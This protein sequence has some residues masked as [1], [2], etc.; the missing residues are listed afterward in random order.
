MK[1]HA[2]QLFAI[3][4]VRD[5]FIFLQPNFLQ[6]NLQSYIGRPARQEFSEVLLPK[7]F[8]NSNVALSSLSPVPDEDEVED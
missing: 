8:C 7:V 5:E 2:V 6:H 1:Y 3:Q 4:K